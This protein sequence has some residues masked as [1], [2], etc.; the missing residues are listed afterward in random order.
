MWFLSSR[1]TLL[2]IKF[3]FKLGKW[4]CGTKL[5]TFTHFTK[6]VITFKK[7]DWVSESVCKNAKQSTWSNFSAGISFITSISKI[8][9][10]ISQLNSGKQSN[11]DR[12][13][14]IMQDGIPVSSDKMKEKNF[15]IFI[16]MMV[17]ILFS[18]DLYFVPFLVLLY[19]KGPWWNHFP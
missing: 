5:A 17:L 10:F 19:I 14:D 6:K 16:K 18:L 13:Y 9:N 8:H 12:K 7:Y 4:T 3:Y 1:I 2:K 11:D 15:L